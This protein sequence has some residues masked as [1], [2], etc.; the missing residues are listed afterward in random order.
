M[1]KVMFKQPWWMDDCTPQLTCQGHSSVKKVQIYDL[2]ICSV[3]PSHGM[4]INQSETEKQ[5]TH[6][7]EAYISLMV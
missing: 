2:N 5:M 1:F 4:N 7:T 3:S 6:E